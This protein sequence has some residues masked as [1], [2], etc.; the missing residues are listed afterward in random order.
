MKI[1]QHNNIIQYIVDNIDD[2]NVDNNGDDDDDNGNGDENDR[3]NSQ[4]TEYQ[5]CVGIFPVHLHLLRHL[6]GQIEKHSREMSNICS[7]CN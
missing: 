1:T 7:E 3:K 6:I 2:D 5:C 4:R